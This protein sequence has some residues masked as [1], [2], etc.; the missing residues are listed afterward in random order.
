LDLKHKTDICIWQVLSN[1]ALLASLAKEKGRGSGVGGSARVGGAVKAGGG[2]GNGVTLGDINRSIGAALAR[3][4]LPPASGG[5]CGRR[6]RA[7]DRDDPAADAWFLRSDL[8]SDGAFGGGGGG[9]SGGS[10][11]R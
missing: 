6:A 5:A 8:H 9:G 1:G 10:A 11:F 2:G 4:L 7:T 3:A